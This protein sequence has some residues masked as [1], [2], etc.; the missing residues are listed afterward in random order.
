MGIL[1][2]ENPVG[3]LGKI[4]NGSGHRVILS[5]SKNRALPQKSAI[6]RGGIEHLLQ[7]AAPSMGG[8]AGKNNVARSRGDYFKLLLGCNLR[9]IQAGEY[10]VF[11]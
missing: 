10:S 8:F 2:N 11:G 4:V 7:N 3:S 9:G 5:E 1:R 6:Y